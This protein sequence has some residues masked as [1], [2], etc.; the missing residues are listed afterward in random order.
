MPLINL[1]EV[2]LNCKIAGKGDS[3]ILL[4]GSFIDNSFW[5]KQVPALSKKFKVISVDLRGHGLSDKPLEEYTPKVM[6]EDIMD[7]MTNLN[8]EKANLVG[9]SMGG[10]IALQFSMDNPRRIKKL[11]LAGTSARSVRS[12]QMVFPKHIQDE[13]GMGTPHFDLKRFNYY[14]VLY[15]FAHPLPDQANKILKMILNTPEHVKASI[16]RNF[17]KIDFT[18]HLSE[19]KSPTLVICGEKDV[20][21]PV[22]YSKY[23]AKHISKARLEIVPEAGHCLPIERPRVFNRQI[24]RFLT[25]DS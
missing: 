18:P 19:I 2:Q 8:I 11:I 20:I 5:S 12:R 1:G 13:I 6:A 9:H 22:K 10:K 17:P 23:I 4:H 21:T 16:G 24:I 14:E 3:C 25:E 15:S 7:L